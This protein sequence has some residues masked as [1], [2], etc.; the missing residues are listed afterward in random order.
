MADTPIA[1]PLTN[2]THEHT[3]YKLAHGGSATECRWA[4]EKPHYADPP[5]CW[6]R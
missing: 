3:V 4:Y 5:G 1:K 2:S 6:H